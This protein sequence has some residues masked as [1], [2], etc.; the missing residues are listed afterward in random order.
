MINPETVR[1]V[2]KQNEDYCRLHNTSTHTE[3][4]DLPDIEI[5]NLWLSYIAQEALKLI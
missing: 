5:E 2:I 4:L 1:R 3:H